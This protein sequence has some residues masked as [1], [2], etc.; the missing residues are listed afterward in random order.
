M[1]LAIE[2]LDRVGERFDG[3]DD[4]RTAGGAHSRSFDDCDDKRTVGGSHSPFLT[5]VMENERRET[6]RQKDQPLLF[7]LHLDGF[8][9]GGGGLGV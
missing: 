1:I 4:K 8:N 3:C 2:T 6:G 9:R 7:A 5:A